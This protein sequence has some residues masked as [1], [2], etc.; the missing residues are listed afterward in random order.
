MPTMQEVIAFMK[1]Q[2]EVTEAFEA[3]IMTAIEA[4]HMEPGFDPNDDPA[5]VLTDKGIEIIE[6]GGTIAGMGKEEEG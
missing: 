6:N 1:T 5:F 3:M 4:G 2:G